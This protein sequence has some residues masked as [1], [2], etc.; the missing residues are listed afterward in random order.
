MDTY[1]FYPL[2]NKSESEKSL[3]DRDIELKIQLAKHGILSKDEHPAITEIK[4]LIDENKRLKE[5]NEDLRRRVEELETGIKDFN[6]DFDE[7]DPD[8]S[9]NEL[10]ELVRDS[11]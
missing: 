2:D 8:R 10:Y 7:E 6:R 3:D 9:I 1:D 11:I 4:K 5:E